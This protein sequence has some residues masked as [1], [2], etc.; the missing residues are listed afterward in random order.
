MSQQQL[1]FYQKQLEEENTSLT[2]NFSQLKMAHKKFLEASSSA[3]ALK[4]EPEGEGA[5][6][7]S[8]R[9]PGSP[10]CSHPCSQPTL[11]SPVQSN[12]QS[13]LSRPKF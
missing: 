1:Q 3:S 9:V 11:Q 2:A 7:A 6:Q 8:A 13:L 5:P 12:L 10:L 4:D